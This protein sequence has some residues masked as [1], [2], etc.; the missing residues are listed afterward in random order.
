MGQEGQWGA[1]PGLQ[2][3]WGSHGRGF[4]HK[5]S[6]KVQRIK[7]MVG[8]ESIA[9][10]MSYHHHLY[11]IQG[12]DKPGAAERKKEAL[13]CN[14]GRDLE[15]SCLM[16]DLCWEG[17]ENPTQMLP[18]LLSNLSQRLLKWLMKKSTAKGEFIDETTTVI[19]LNSCYDLYFEGLDEIEQLVKRNK[20][21]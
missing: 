14:R 15:P 3:S 10:T 16:P 17:K 5:W 21:F 20:M 12:V 13:W 6:T 19:V 4:C 9:S 8:A 18:H 7:T 1:L 11:W 2:L